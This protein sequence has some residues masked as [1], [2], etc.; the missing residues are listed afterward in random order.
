M[1]I[2]SPSRS[3]RVANKDTTVIPAGGT[4]EGGRTCT[5][6]KIFAEG[7]PLESQPIP[8]PT[9]IRRYREEVANYAGNRRNTTERH[10]SELRRVLMHIGDR[11]EKG[12]MEL[13]IPSMGNKEVEYVHDTAP[14]GPQN[15]Y[16]QTHIFRTFLK[17][18]GII[19][20]P[21]ATPLPEPD[22]PRTTPE[23]Y[24]M[25]YRKALE[26]GD[27]VGATVV[28][29][30]S[31]TIR[32]IG[33]M[34]LIPK[35]IKPT[36]INVLDKGRNGGT[37]R[38][39]PITPDVWEQLQQYLAWRKQKIQEVL[40]RRP[41]CPIPT[42]LI[43]WVGV[44]AM[45]NCGRT[46]MDSIVLAVGARVGIHLTHHPMRRMG[47]RELRKVCGDRT[48]IAMKISGHT[49]EKTFL[50]YSGVEE[51]EKASLMQKMMEERQKRAKTLPAT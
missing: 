2:R 49:D 4:V 25:A 14:G 10:K 38:T 9:T 15:I 36:H 21:I 8:M 48:D 18:H 20:E 31:L 35:D 19:T 30:E 6:R 27:I 29:L 16:Y 43:I 44:N 32:R 13:H 12:G 5:E 46:K 1:M 45:G 28:L 3:Y 40:E 37:P 47:C 34:R 24:D 42:K 11:L 50:T 23:Q 17:R 51:E 41:D 7:K 33:V 26:A 39:I 22:R